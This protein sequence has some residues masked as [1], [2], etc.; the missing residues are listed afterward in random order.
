[1]ARSIE[2]CGQIVPCIV[3]AVAGGDGS[4]AGA[5]VLVDGCR[6]VTALRRLGRDTAGVELWSCDL[7]QALLS[8]L[9]RV[10][11]GPFASIEHALLLREVLAEQGLDPFP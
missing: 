4:D 10:Q 6:R 1:L 7:T 5:V 8:V 11:D 2:R 9:A 3:V